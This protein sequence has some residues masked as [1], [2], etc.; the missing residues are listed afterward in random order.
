MAGSSKKAR[1]MYLQMVQSVQISRRLPK[2][3]RVDGPAIS[4]TE[5]DARQLHHPH[6]NALVVSLS[7]ASFNT[8]QVLVDNGS[9]TNIVYYLA[10]QQMM[11]NKEHPM[12][13]DT[14][15]VEFSGIKVFPVGTI[16]LLV[17]IGKYPQ[18]LTKEINFLFVDYSSAYNVIIGR[19][20]LNAWRAATSTYYMLVKFSM[21]YRIGEARGDQI[22]ACECYI[23]MLEMDDHLQALNIEERRVAIEPTKDLEEISLDNNIPN[24]ITHIDT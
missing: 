10:F 21:K 2:V 22:A 9:S 13:S 15:L 8:R 16:T 17:T 19:P 24:R 1:K 20:T 3:T 18:Q 11:V 6:D 12:P 14:P 23:A 4:F 5:E 7:I